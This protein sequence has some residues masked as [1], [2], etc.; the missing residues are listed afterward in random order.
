MNELSFDERGLAMK[1]GDIPEWIY[2]ATRSIME[3]V[4]INNE[5]VYQHCN[6]VG[7]A[8]G[9]LAK[10]A[11]L[12][13]YEQ[14]LA[15]FAGLF[16]DVGKVGIP[17]T[18]L[19]KPGKLTN[20]EYSIMKKHPIL[21]AQALVPLAKHSFV[22]E[23]VEPVL[24][25]HERLDGRGYPHGLRGDD[26]PLISRIILI[27]DTYDAMAHTRPYRKGLPVDVIY[28][29]LKTYAGTQFDSQLAT[30]FMEAHRFQQKSAV[31][32]PNVGVLGRVA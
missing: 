13:E 7:V 21:S 17:D 14:K 10:A 18:I 11:G 26:I 4:R 3:V 25:H 12:N 30:I 6:R 20:D 19:M 23:L 28:T 15:E 31:Q 2:P 9:F 22:K 29:E 24:H 27:V 8:A 1:W 16:H 5:E 32:Q